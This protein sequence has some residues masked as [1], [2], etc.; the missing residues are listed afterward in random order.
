MLSRKSKDK[1]LKE[2]VVGRYVKKNTPSEIPVINV[3]S[4]DD[5]KNKGKNR[6]NSQQ[7]NTQKTEQIGTK[8]KFGN[9]KIST[10]ANTLNQ[11]RKYTPN[12]SVQSLTQRHERLPGNIYSP[13]SGSSSGHNHKFQNMPSTSDAADIFPSRRPSSQSTMSIPTNASMMG[14][15]NNINSNSNY[16]NIEQIDRM[17]HQSEQLYSNSYHPSVEN[18]NRSHSINQNHPH[19]YEINTGGAYGAEQYGAHY[20]NAAAAKKT[21]R[22]PSPM[23]S[24]T[25]SL[26]HS[27]QTIMQSSSGYSSEVSP[28]YENQSQISAQLAASGRSESPIY[29]NTSSNHLSAAYQNNDRYGS[30][31]SHQ[32]V[33]SNMPTEN[34]TRSYQHLGQNVALMPAKIPLYQ[35][36]RNYEAVGMT[37]GEHLVHNARHQVIPHVP[38][39]QSMDEE[40]PLPP[41]WAAYYTLRG[42]KYYIDHN[43]QTTHWSHPLEREGLPIG[44][45]KIVS[46]QHGIYYYNYINRQ[47]QRNHPCLTSCYLYTS[48]EPPNAILPEPQPPQYSPHSALVPANPYLLEK[49]PE[50]LIVYFHADPSKDHILKFNM[51][52]LQK[53]ECFDAMFLK[54]YKQELFSIVGAYEMYR[55]ALT[56]EINRR[57]EQS[58]LQQQHQ[59]QQQQQLGP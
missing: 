16:V 25:S 34:P 5:S 3:W 47:S 2:G 58:R 57:I 30:H 13:E 27:Q 12:L 36:L 21:G 4:S 6:R 45:Q 19:T 54:L 26:G 28:I 46:P 52:G 1:S 7:L 20:S 44:W 18:F 35:P 59:Q 39:Q 8:E 9:T 43:A 37:F 29:C 15:N 50:W 32:S 10:K 14:G 22:N 38:S 40:L 23:S 31:S 55:R 33:Y 24:T 11:I 48:T 51:F 41:G 17:R 42:R 53:L 56:I 49:I